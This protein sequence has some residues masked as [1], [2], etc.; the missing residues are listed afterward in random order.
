[1]NGTRDDVP[2]PEAAHLRQRLLDRRP[3]PEVVGDV[4]TQLEVPDRDGRGERLGHRLGDEA[5]QVLEEHRDAA[6][7]MLRDR[8]P[9]GL[10]VSTGE[11]V[12]QV[13]G[14]E[15]LHRHGRLDLTAGLPGRHRLL[16]GPHVVVAVVGGRP[17]EDV[18]R[19]DA[20]DGEQLGRSRGR[21]PGRRAAT[22]PPSAGGSATGSSR[23][24]RSSASSPPLPPWRPSCGAPG[25]RTRGWSTPAVALVVRQFPL[26]MIGQRLEVLGGLLVVD[27]DATDILEL[28]DASGS[29]LLVPGKGA[30]LVDRR[31][32]VARHRDHLAE[33]Q[34][35]AAAERHPLAAAALV[36]Q[37]LMF[38][39]IE[40]LHRDRTHAA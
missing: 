32:V 2:E 17:D 14:A 10:D 34:R 13:V 20:E 28:V 19:R 30:H 9:L 3:R 1:M 26:L 6:V 11:R 31:E 15:G 8:Q 25:G 24:G 33:R 16:D 35:V 38:A 23:R 18:R 39:G 22:V 21:G 5:D 7:P 4:G 40:P 37:P 36:S 12:R 29:R 27:V